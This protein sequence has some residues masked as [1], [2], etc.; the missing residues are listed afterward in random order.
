M[1]QCPRLLWLIYLSQKRIL[2]TVR[3]YIIKLHHIAHKKSPLTY[4]RGQDTESE[5][6]SLIV[7]HDF[8]SLFPI[9]QFIKSLHIMAFQFG[10]TSLSTKIFKATSNSGW[11]L[12]LLK[13]YLLTCT[14]IF[15]VR[16]VFNNI[17][18]VTLCFTSKDHSRPFLFI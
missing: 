3:V 6:H 12:F 5:N 9:S 8:G 2:T 17:L 18:L 13:R 4:L 15:L 10:M 11:M 7:S 14:S 1:D 16:Y